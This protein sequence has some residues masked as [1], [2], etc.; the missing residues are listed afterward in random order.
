MGT[1][2]K[3]TIGLSIFTGVSAVNWNS[4]FLNKEQL[5]DSGREWMTLDN[6]IQFQPANNMNPP[7]DYVRKLSSNGFQENPYQSIFV[8]GTS[9]YYDEYSQAWRA[10]GFYID[11]DA[12]LYY[13]DGDDNDNENEN[14]NENDEGDQTNYGCQRFLLWAAVSIV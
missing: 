14:E 12:K 10:L 2:M 1:K 5:P 8:D 11:C 6:G 7:L 13:N 4:L 3:A 9:T